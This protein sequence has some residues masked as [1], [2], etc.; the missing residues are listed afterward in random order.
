MQILLAPDSFKHSL[1][2]VEIG[3]TVR[4]CLQL[5]FPF[6][7]TIFVPLADGG[8]GSLNA[9]KAMLRFQKI[10]STT[11]NAYAGP[12]KSYYLWDSC[13]RTAHV[14]LAN[15]IGIE[16]VKNKPNILLA[17]S[18][19]AGKVLA[20]VLKKQPIKIY[21][22]QGSTATNDAGVGLLEALGFL[23][24]SGDTKLQNIKVLDLHLVD[25]IVPP[26]L[27]WPEII[28]A[29]DV[30]NPFT[31]RQG[32]THTFAAQKG[33]TAH[34]I[35][36][37]EKQLQAYHT[38]IQSTYKI[39]LN[40]IP[41][42]GAAGGISGSLV[43]LT[44][45]TIKSGSRLLFDFLGVEKKIKQADLVIS[46][47]GQTDRQ[48]LHGKLVFE[49]AQLARLHGKKLWLICGKNSLTNAELKTL[50]VEKCFALRSYAT[51][52]E[53]SIINAGSILKS[54]LCMSLI[55]HLKKELLQ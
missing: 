55:Q 16:L 29:T 40:Q 42:S 23:F 20:D 46:G 9:L 10:N 11:I 49:V 5:H 34:Q 51:T 22:W 25:K 13:T 28:L 8:E 30:N 7:Q 53:S 17:S 12:V 44:G 32:A 41:G 43:A 15:S 26:A 38:F 2:S 14:E 50:G 27:T 19:G 6:V 36:Q 45:A 21:V 24:Y 37:M 18:F 33:A 31:G 52:D 47:E 1:S 35:I 4:N 3:K 39:N 54:K 48:T